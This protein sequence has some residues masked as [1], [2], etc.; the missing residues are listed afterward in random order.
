MYAA[1]RSLGRTSV[2][3][4]AV[5]LSEREISVSSRL[6]QQGYATMCVGK[7]H[8]GDQNQFLPICY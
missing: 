2:L 7:W 1:K 5:G 6:Q 3:I 8:L 4:S